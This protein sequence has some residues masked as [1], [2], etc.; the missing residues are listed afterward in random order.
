MKDGDFRFRSGRL[1]LDFA[2]T[3]GGRYRSPVE[4]LSAPE[5]LG[6]WLCLALPVQQEVTV[7]QRE[8]SGAIDLREAAYRLL[9]PATRNHPADADVAVLNKWAAQHVFAPQLAPGARTMVLH[10]SQPA[11]AGLAV[12]ARDAIDLLS[13]SWLGRVRECSRPDCSLLFADFSRPGQRRWCD[14]E[15]CGNRAKVHR[16]RS[17]HS[18]DREFQLASDA[19]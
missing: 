6:R 10:A 15:S 4:R 19:S 16:Y 5:N 1:C 14:M 11:R 9:H 17:A 2:A 18:G 13:G 12:V 8:L 3:L 7:T